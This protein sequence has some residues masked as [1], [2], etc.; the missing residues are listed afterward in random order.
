MIGAAGFLV[1][2]EAFSVPLPLAAVDNRATLNPAYHWLAGQAPEP[3]LVLV[4]LPLHSAPAPEYPE[5]KRLYASTRGWWQLVNGYSGY[6]PDRQPK[7]A[8]KLTSFPDAVA[9]TALQ[10]LAGSETDAPTGTAPDLYVLV[11]PDEAPLD[12]DRW[13]TTGRW[14]ADRNP[15]LAPIGQFNGSYLYRLRPVTTEPATLTSL[16][17]FGQNRAIQLTGFSLDGCATTGESCQN[18]ALFWT[19]NERVPLEATVF[20]HLRAADGF[21]RD[22]ADGPPV[23]GQYPTT[24]WQPGEVIEDI[25]R[26]PPVENNQIDHLAIGLYDPLTGERLPAYGPDGQRLPDDAVLIPYP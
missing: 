19:T 17:S 2:L 16:A 13:E 18:L 6:T 21:V 24:A 8:E 25:H 15:L 22:Q 11:H 10:E 4:E 23:S 12:R 7:L 5:V 9:I 20:I 14:L 3:G 1:V 26:L